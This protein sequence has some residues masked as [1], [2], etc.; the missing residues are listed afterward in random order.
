VTQVTA[1]VTAG[2]TTPSAAGTVSY[3]Y[4]DDAE[5]PY[6]T[7]L[8]HAISGTPVDGEVIAGAP[9]ANRFGNGGQVRLYTPDARP[10]SNPELNPRSKVSEAVIAHDSGAKCSSEDG[11]RFG[12][13]LHLGTETAAYAADHQKPQPIRL[14]IGVP[15]EDTGA[16]VDV[17]AVARVD[18][19]P[20]AQ[21][22]AHGSLVASDGRCWTQDT[23]GI[24]GVAEAGDRFGTAVQSLALDAGLSPVFVAG[25]P[26]EDVGGV[27]DSGGVASLGGSRW[28]DEGSA[29]VPGARGTGDRFGAALGSARDVAVPQPT[30][31]IP[32]GPG[33]W[34]RGLVV[35][36]PGKRSG[37]GRVILGLP[38]GSVLGGTAIAPPAGAVAFGAALSATH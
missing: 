25:A 19:V 28:Y 11:D 5:H 31:S 38:Y 17:G 7:L 9:G 15:T 33:T 32:S 29:G 10:G 1:T 34:S 13:S 35:G 8:G 30:G 2:D 23:A 21:P 20:P 4:D 6:R 22:G 37:R 16:R 14:F 26:G 3:S 24:S 36:V 18:Y 27:V 12:A